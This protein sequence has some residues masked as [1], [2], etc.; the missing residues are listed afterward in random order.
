MLFLGAPQCPPPSTHL[1]ND[2]VH[3]AW[4]CVRNRAHR[5]IVA[6]VRVIDPLPRIQC[7][8]LQILWLYLDTYQSRISIPKRVCDPNESTEPTTGQDECRNDVNGV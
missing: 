8:Q 5:I 2:D 3:R 6:P 7:E 1:T 4:D